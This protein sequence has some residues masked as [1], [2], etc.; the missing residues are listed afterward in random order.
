M[1]KNTELL[2]LEIL[3]IRHITLDEKQKLRHWLLN[4]GFIGEKEV[5]GWIHDFG[6]AFWMVVYDYWFYYQKKMQADFL[7]IKEKQWLLLE[8]KNFD[9]KFEYKNHECIMN[10]RVMNDNFIVNMSNKI[11][12]IKNIAHEI[13][14][15]IEVV[16]AMI[17]INEHCQVEM[18]HPVD[19]EIILRNQ[20]KQFLK[21]FVNHS[22][23]PLPHEYIERVRTVLNQYATDSPFQ[24]TGLLPDQ[25]AKVKKGITCQECHSFETVASKKKI[26]CKL[27]GHKELKAAAIIRST[28]Q[29]RY[30][31]F[32][33]PEMITTTN[34][35]DFMGGKVSLATVRYTLAREFQR[36]GL[37]KSSYYLVDLPADHLEI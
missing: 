14:P 31:F 32:D 34:V 9:G 18:N 26:V 1:Q 24:P 4:L 10:S 23:T 12:R 3:T 5:D 17:F 16:S 22:S 36:V 11:R 13:S 35:F 21:R 33:H 6:D 29:L 28:K 2:Q 20:F 30:V 25:F 15:D 27:C 7:I 37:T 8:V 19:F